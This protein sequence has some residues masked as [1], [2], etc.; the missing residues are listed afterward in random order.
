MC[1]GVLR[2]P[3]VFL[4]VRCSNCVCCSILSLLIKTVRCSICVCCSILSLLIKTV[5]CGICVCCSILSLLI[6]TVHCSICVCCSLLNLL[7]KTAR[8]SISVCCSILSLLIKL[9]IVASFVVAYPTVICNLCLCRAVGFNNVSFLT[10]EMNHLTFCT[11]F[12]NFL[13]H[14]ICTK[15][16]LY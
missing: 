7:I 14:C 8:C 4:R 15:F 16:V 11:F 9:F 2:W 1:T 10:R 3:K 13:F 6:K 12:N 5:H